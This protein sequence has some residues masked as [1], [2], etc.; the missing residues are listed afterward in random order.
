[1]VARRQLLELGLGR[2]A[3]NYR[4][5]SERLTPLSRGVYTLDVG[6]A[7]RERR[8]MAAVRASG[9]GPVLSH[10]PA[11]ALWGIRP[12]DP[13]TIDVSVRSRGKRS[14][15]GLRVHRA[16]RLGDV[17]VTVRRGVPVTSAS[18]TLIDVAEAVSR[19]ALERALDEAEY[20]RLFDATD[21]AR[22]SRSAI[23]GGRATPG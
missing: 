13:I 22:A 6:P 5:R 10:L 8:W 1:M 17:E 3:I 20:L 14:V 16:R 18:R 2:E 7:S 19:R 11:A 21:L 12:Q 4:E 23:A 9:E 15:E